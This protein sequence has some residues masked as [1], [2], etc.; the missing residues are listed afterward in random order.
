MSYTFNNTGGTNYGIKSYN[1]IFALNATNT[2]ASNYWDPPLVSGD[3][4]I[5]ELQYTISSSL[6]KNH[7]LL[8]YYDFDQGGSLV[9]GKHWIGTGLY[10]CYNNDS[11]TINPGQFV[12]QWQGSPLPGGAGS[13]TPVVV[14]STSGE[15]TQ[16]LGVAVEKG[17]AGS[18]F[19]VAMMGVWPAL[20]DGVLAYDEAIYSTYDSSGAVTLTVPSGSYNKGAFGKCISLDYSIITTKTEPP[21]TS[22]GC[23]VCIWGT[24]AETL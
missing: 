14:A 18:F 2:G 17:T 13:R 21:E 11:V 19:M 16:P 9:Y 15:A 5:M 1:N 23:L 6:I 4:V 22:D 7:K 3:T 20:R 10:L 12:C 8:T 24:S